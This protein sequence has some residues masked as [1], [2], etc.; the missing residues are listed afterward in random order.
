MPEVVVKAKSDPSLTV[1]DIETK[2][3]EL[4]KIPGAAEVINSDSY[5]RGRSTTIRDALDFAPGVFVQSR[6]GAEEA[7]ISIRG[8]GIQRTF[9]GRGIELLQDDVPLNLAD[10]SFDF[11]A[12]E[13]LATRYIEVYRGANSLQFGSTTL[14]GALNFVSFTGY[15]APPLTARVEYGSF[16]SFRAQL[17]SGMVI[18]PLDYYVSLTT[19]LTDGYRE[20]GKQAS[21]RIFSNAGYR[22]SEEVETRFYFTYV[23]T[24]SELPGALTKQQ[25]EQDPRQAAQ[26]NVINNWKRDFYLVRLANK[27]VWQQGDHRIESTAF[28][29]YKDLHHPI[30]V[31]IDQLSND[32]GISLRYDNS[33]EIFGSQNKFTVGF[34]T[35]YGSAQDNRYQNVL[36]NPGMQISDSDQYSLNLNLFVQDR[37]YLVDRLALVAGTAVTYAR[38]QNVDNFPVSAT[39]PDN[40][41]IESY[42]GFSPQVGLLLEITDA[43][44]AFVNVSRSFE[45]PTFGELGNP[46]DAGAGIIQLE[47]QTA[48]TIEAGT[49]GQAGR[50]EWDLAYYFSWLED[51]LIEYEVI[52][53]LTKTVNAG[54]TV[55]QGIEFGLHIDVFRGIFCHQPS[56]VFSPSGGDK[57]VNNLAEPSTDRIVLRQ[58]G[59][60]N[61]FRF[62][63][64]PSYGNNRLPGIPPFYYRA[65]LLY[66]HP[67]GFY[68]GPNVEWVPFGYSVDSTA[69]V[70]A[71]PYA[72]LGFKIG[73]RSRKGLAVF[74]EAKNVTNTNYAAT[75][76]VT[77]RQ[78]A[79]NQAQF[80]PGDGTA[81]YGGVEWD[82]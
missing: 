56:Q 63:N 30:F 11:Q 36:G 77:A 54:R 9:H 74:F 66:E 27:T 35:A 8:S 75:T 76:G 52:P 60:W 44:Q 48:T 73:Y 21:F 64:D 31:V 61:D 59:L 4:A 71:D 49:R 15:D 14:G 58:V 38:R 19:G 51:E 3:R 55:H 40:S 34:N 72:L 25:L 2:R 18:G 43:A 65:E 33:G 80:F 26:T 12:V 32:F 6:F 28:W 16:Q 37:F 24:D 23:L 10:G 70:F 69:T 67:S 45:P 20:H 17:S 62:V 29:S 13:P 79:F 81:F 82:W 57:S 78:T 50:V 1:P 39:D 47:A 7:R 68:A 5:K 42:W 53:G 22:P 46:A 41:G